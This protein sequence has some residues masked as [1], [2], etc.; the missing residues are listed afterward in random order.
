MLPKILQNEK[1][2]YEMLRQNH[3]GIAQSVELLP[4]GILLVVYS[5]G[6]LFQYVPKRRVGLVGN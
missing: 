2:V 1:R 6:D 3:P 4:D 5:G